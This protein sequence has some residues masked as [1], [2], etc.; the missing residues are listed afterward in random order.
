VCPLARLKEYE[1]SGADIQVPLG[2]ES[3]FGRLE[4]HPGTFIGLLPLPG[5]LFPKIHV[6]LVR[7]IPKSAVVLLAAPVL[8]ESAGREKHSRGLQRVR[9]DRVT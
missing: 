8:R 3:V 2:D 1:V 5:E 9:P 4:R 6:V 7:S